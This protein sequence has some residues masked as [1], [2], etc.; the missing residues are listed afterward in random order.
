MCIQHTSVPHKGSECNFI[1]QSNLS[2]VTEFGSFTLT[3]AA[4]SLQKN[5]IG[6]TIDSNFFL[7][8]EPSLPRSCTI[9]LTSEGRA[10]IYEAFLIPRRLLKLLS[11]NYNENGIICDISLCC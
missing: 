4:N 5:L 2:R 6:K 1:F 3:K 11:E 10:K 9:K 7:S 8:R